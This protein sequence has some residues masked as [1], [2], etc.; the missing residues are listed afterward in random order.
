MQWRLQSQGRG[1]STEKTECVFVHEPPPL[2]TLVSVWSGCASAPLALAI[3]AL[4]YRDVER[5]FARA[6]RQHL[7]GGLSGSK[8][9]G[10]CLLGAA[11][12]GGSG[13]FSEKHSGVPW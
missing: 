13:V 10:Q 2:P 1:L 11:V 4:P 12:H 9:E 8:R 3:A 6:Y 5:L 7:T